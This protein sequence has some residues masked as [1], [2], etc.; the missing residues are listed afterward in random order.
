MLN[1]GSGFKIVANAAKLEPGDE[2]MTWNNGT[3]D[4]VYDAGCTVHLGA[5]LIEIVAAQPPCLMNSQSTDATGSNNSG[6]P[7]VPGTFGA[8]GTAPYLI[9]AAV[10]GGAAVI[11]AAKS[12]G[13]TSGGSSSPNP[14]PAS[15]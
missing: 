1:T 9:G 11:Y 6:L 8:G 5:G 15:P 2:I 7:D 14:L 4:I 3:A 12:T 10:A 13:T